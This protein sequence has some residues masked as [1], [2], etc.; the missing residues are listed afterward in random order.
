MTYLLIFISKY[1]IL[2][3]NPVLLSSK[4]L[5]DQFISLVLG[6]QV[7]VLGPQVLVLVLEPQVLVL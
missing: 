1:A 6:L 2:C 3:C 4:S 5:K 7:L